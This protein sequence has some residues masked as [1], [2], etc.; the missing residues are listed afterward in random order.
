MWDIRYRPLKF[1]DVL[2]QAGAVQL[3]KSRLRNG[4]ALD[5]CYIFAGG[6]GQ[7]KTTLARILA[8]AS[9]CLDLDTSDPEPC[10]ACDNCTAVLDGTPGAFEER[11][12]ASG[13]TV[14]V[15]RSMV[16]DLPFSILNA[17]KRVWLFDEAHRM[18]I[19]AQ[20]V[21]LKPLE[22][23]KVVGIF[24]TTEPEKIRGPIR[25]RCEEYTIR[26]VTRED[27]L[28]RMKYI[29]TAEGVSHDDDAI[30]TVIDYSGGHVRDVVNRLEMIAQLGGITLEGVREYLNL[31]LV[32]IYYDVLLSLGDIGRALS[33]VESACERVTPDEVAAG[34]AEAAMNSYRL[35]NGMF[36]D[37][38][39]ADKALAKRVYEQYGRN[40]INIAEFFLQRRYP[41]R[42]SLLCDVMRFTERGAHSAPVAIS[43]EPP[44]RVVAATPAVN[45]APTSTPTVTISTATEITPLV[46]TAS[47]PIPQASPAIQVQKSTNGN[48]KVRSDGVGPRGSGDVLA[49]TDLDHNG[50]PQS[51]PRMR[52]STGEIP[53]PFVPGGVV[54]DDEARLL[55]PE[56][57]KREFDRISP[58]R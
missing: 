15:V 44:V 31:G 5:S 19:G 3:L 38:V 29:L 17:S 51:G 7:G 47:N 49:L 21:L 28:A 25:S 27:V 55:S 14:D 43:N 45:H 26:K 58:W 41:S 12:A 57:W 30:L 37:F 18:T 36:A 32:S 16:D 46:S 2:G 39:Y 10:N 20:D 33:L 8:R 52:T 35:A 34:L 23:K 11:D 40:S 4:T 53:P 9:L 1:S 48:G 56:E 50:V 6:H 42:T 54:I 24:C 22:E 13:G